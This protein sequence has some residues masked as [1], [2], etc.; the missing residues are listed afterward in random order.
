[1][2]K[3]NNCIIYG[4]PIKYEK[5]GVTIENSY[6]IQGDKVLDFIRDIKAGK[7]DEMKYA[8]DLP[9]GVVE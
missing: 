2:L 8:D 1:M 7:A 4:E 3:I 9:G 6:V 5:D